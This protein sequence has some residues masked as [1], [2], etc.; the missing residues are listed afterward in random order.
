VA[1]VRQC[2]VLV[3]SSNLPVCCRALTLLFLFTLQVIL[4][5]D[6]DSRAHLPPELQ[7]SNALIMTVAQAKG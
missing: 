1:A 5:R 6:M 2:A 4:V 3:Y 7:H